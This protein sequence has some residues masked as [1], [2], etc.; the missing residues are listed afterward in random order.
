MNTWGTVSY[1]DENHYEVDV[2]DLRVQIAKETSEISTIRFQNAVTNEQIACPDD[3]TLID[4]DGHVV[5]KLK[6]GFRIAW[7]GSYKLER[8]GSCII[9][10][11]SKRQQCIR[12]AETQWRTINKNGQV[13]DEAA[14]TNC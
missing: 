2:E 1:H 9:E 10:I 13:I 11:T 12:F 4:A 6:L 5:P 8:N 7:N 3:I 14:T